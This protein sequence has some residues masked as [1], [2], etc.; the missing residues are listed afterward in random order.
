MIENRFRQ[1]SDSAKLLIEFYQ[2]DKV[3]P[4]KLTDDDAMLAGVPTGEEIRKLFRKWYGEPIPTLYR[5]WFRVKDTTTHDL[6]YS[7]A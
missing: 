3:D 4:Y 2:T 7:P 5:N 6:L 1:K